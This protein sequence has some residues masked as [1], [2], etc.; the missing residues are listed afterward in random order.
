MKFYKDKFSVIISPISRSR[1]NGMV[2]CFQKSNLWTKYS[3]EANNYNNQNII[4]IIIIIITQQKNNPYYFLIFSNQ[5][6]I[7]TE[8]KYYTY[9]SLT[10][11]LGK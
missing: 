8:K 7:R 11:Q 3:T 5:D 6:I 4:I 9:T 10:G 2:R 1:A